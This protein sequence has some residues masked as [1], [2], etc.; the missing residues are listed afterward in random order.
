MTRMTLGAHLMALG[1]LSL[2]AGCAEETATGE[3][4]VHIVKNDD[5]PAENEEVPVS[6]SQI[7]HAG[8]Q[9]HVSKNIA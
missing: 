8:L 1:L 6:R 7:D 3:Q 2:A 5:A 9:N 4:R